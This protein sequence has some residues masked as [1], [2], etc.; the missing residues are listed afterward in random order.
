MDTILT[1]FTETYD[2]LMSDAWTALNNMQEY[3]DILANLNTFDINTIGRAPGRVAELQK[4]RSNFV[5]YVKLIDYVLGS[6]RI[7][8]TQRN[9]LDKSEINEADLNSIDALIASIPDTQPLQDI[10]DQL[11]AFYPKLDFVI[12][13]LSIQPVNYYRGKVGVMDA[14]Q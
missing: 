10:R 8:I 1:R 12:N 9:E 7:F 13:K 5:I 11:M 3:E 4:L 2:R 6:A 14:S